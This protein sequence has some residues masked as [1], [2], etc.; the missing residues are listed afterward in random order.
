MARS[1]WAFLG[2]GLKI[3][4]DLYEPGDIGISLAGATTVDSYN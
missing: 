2:A 1:K 3:R 4:N